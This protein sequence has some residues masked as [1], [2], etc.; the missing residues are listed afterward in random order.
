MR[1]CPFSQLEE[2]R[3]AFEITRS[4]R[5]P[6]RC[7]RVIDTLSREAQDRSRRV[8]RSK[9]SGTRACLEQCC[10]GLRVPQCTISVEKL[11]IERI[12]QERLPE[13]VQPIF[14][15]RDHAG[16]ECTV[17]DIHD[18]RGRSFARK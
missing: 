18:L 4:S 10:G 9:V 1:E 7:K 2:A 14:F 11:A 3:G 16:C 17:E 6:M 5:V 12:A 15:A 8:V 13:T